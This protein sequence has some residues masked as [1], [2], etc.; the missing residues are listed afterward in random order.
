MRKFRNWLFWPTFVVCTVLVF[1]TIFIGWMTRSHRLV[2][3]AAWLWG[4]AVLWASG[5]KL[6]VVGKIPEGGPFVVVPNHSSVL[7]IAAAL[8]LCENQL[9]FRFVSRQSWFWIPVFGQAALFA[10]CPAVNR[11]KPKRF[12]Q[13]RGKLKHFV[14]GQSL[15]M[16][17]EGTRTLDG[18]I[19]K[20]KGGAFSLAAEHDVPILPV[21]FRGLYESMPKHKYL[22]KMLTAKAYIGP[23]MRVLSTAKADRLK[24]GEEVRNWIINAGQP[25]S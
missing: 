9:N 16:F 17:A 5:V 23:P 22:P 24:A 1:I 14:R 12:N 21:R 13:R 6:E 2:S 4:V 25:S 10:G 7:D 19:G 15:M 11:K 8:V 20:F 18:T 3:K